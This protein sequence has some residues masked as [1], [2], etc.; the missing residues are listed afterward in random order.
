[1][2]D[3]NGSAAMTP[4]SPFEEGGPSLANGQLP[5]TDMEGAALAL[6][7]HPH[8]CAR[9]LLDG[10][11]SLLHVI[12]T[13]N[14]ITLSPDCAPEAASP[15]DPLAQE[16]VQVLMHVC[17]SG[18]W[19]APRT[20]IFPSAFESCA[21]SSTKGGESPSR[22]DSNNSGAMPVVSL[23]GAPSRSLLSSSVEHLMLSC[24]V[25]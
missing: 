24:L 23:R 16:H 12:I 18:Q 5:S 17:E 19:E 21:N 10:P 20:N 3:A 9:D 8:S 6:L 7:T 2:Q 14:V 15:S 25:E 4:R 13:L 1:V 22:V 11:A